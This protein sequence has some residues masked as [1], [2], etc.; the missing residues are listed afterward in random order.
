MDEFIGVNDA[1]STGAITNQSPVASSWCSAWS[2][3][4]KYIIQVCG[5][6]GMQVWKY[7]CMCVCVCM[8]VCTYVCMDGCM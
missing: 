5:Y 1:N 6:V 4:A 8:Y 7:V 3:E 2:S